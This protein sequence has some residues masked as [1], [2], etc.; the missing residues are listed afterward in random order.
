MTINPTLSV[1]TNPVHVMTIAIQDL[2]RRVEMLER[3]AGN[4]VFPP[5]TPWTADII[6]GGAVAMTRRQTGYK[7]IG[8]LVVAS[9][10]MVAAGAGTGNNMITM[11]AP[12]PFRNDS[13]THLMSVG[14]CYM[15]AGAVGQIT[16]S[17]CI[18]GD[19]SDRFRFIRQDAVY[20]NYIGVDP[21]FAIAANTFI[22][23]GTVVYESAP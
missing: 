22:L 8:S 14:T 5:W 1:T 7:R 18:V 12:I 15:Q 10:A 3:F 23:S 6:Q 17:V 2:Q 9:F 21:N 16:A 20:T 4:S 11:S 13:D 19:G